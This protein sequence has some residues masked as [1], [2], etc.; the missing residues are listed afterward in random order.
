MVGLLDRTGRKASKFT[1]EVG[2]LD[3]HSGTVNFIRRHQA[4]IEGDFRGGFCRQKSASYF[5]QRVGKGLSI[6]SA[7]LKNGCG[8][9]DL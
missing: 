2:K 9:P 4:E 3:L 8:I 1:G 7:A 5:S 6:P